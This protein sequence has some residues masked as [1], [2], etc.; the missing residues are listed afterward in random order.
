VCSAKQAVFIGYFI[1]NKSICNNISGG[2]GSGEIVYLPNYKLTAGKYDI[3]IGGK[4]ISPLITGNIQIVNGITIP[5]INDNTSNCCIFMYNGSITFTTSVIC[6]IFMIGGG[7]GGGYNHGGGG[8]AGAYY[9]GTQTLSAGT[10]KITVGDGGKGG[11]STTIGSTNGENTSISLNGSNIL[12][13][14]GGGYG[15]GDDGGKNNLSIILGGNGG[16]G[17]GGGSYNSTT[18]NNTMRAGGSALNTNT[19]GTGFAGGSGMDNYN[20]SALNGGGGG[21]IGGSG[22]NGTAT[23]GGTGGSGLLIN[24]TGKNLPFGAGGGGGAWRG[25]GDIP[26]IAGNINIYTIGGEGYGGDGAS[27]TG[28]G[29][30]GGN[31]GGGRG[32][33]GGSGIVIIKYR[34]DTNTSNLNNIININNSNALLNTNKLT[35]ITRSNLDLLSAKGGGDGELLLYLNKDTLNLNLNQDA[36]IIFI[37]V[38][39][40]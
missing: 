33:N 31:E 5:F 35:S 3:Q 9:N 4:L 26:G 23:Q 38:T 24:I 1:Q 27:G 18:V 28:S 36:N 10:Y 12:I 17:G 6:D 30:G 7:G 37:K 22:T 29:G 11:K 34:I 13:V 20:G 21:G 14:N 2:G 19:N 8:G 40:I 25:V 16:C 15:G 39:I 32:G